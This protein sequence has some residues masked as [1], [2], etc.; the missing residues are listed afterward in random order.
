MLVGRGP[1]YMV[2][3]QFYD[4]KMVLALPNRLFFRA[5]RHIIFIFIPRLGFEDLMKMSTLKKKQNKP[6]I[7][8]F[9]VFFLFFF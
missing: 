4:K 6:G 1:P 3:K 8:G 9:F 2:E 5:K 7:V